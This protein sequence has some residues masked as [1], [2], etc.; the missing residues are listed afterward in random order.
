[1]SRS[2]ALTAAG[3]LTLGALGACGE[4]TTSDDT[5]SAA[6]ETTTEVEVMDPWVRSTTGTED[7]SMTAA[8][9]T[10][11]NQGEEDAELVSAKSDVAGMAQLHEM[12][13]GDDGMVMQEVEDGIAIPAGEGVALAPGSYHVMLM[14]L[15]G[16][17][18]PGD[19][20]SFT[21]TYADGSTQ[22]V[23]APVKEFTEE[24]GHYHD[25][26]DHDHGKDG[27]DSSA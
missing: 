22:D 3:V 20:V 21:L 27:K 19:E 6:A 9:M 23:T 11:M 1:M 10:L 2:L 7:P 17:L 18:A 8:F 4:E 24:E 13:S 16:E 15:S 26:G 14:D 25:H 5:T 12:A